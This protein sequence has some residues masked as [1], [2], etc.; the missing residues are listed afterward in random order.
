MTNPL[1][2]GDI[3]DMSTYPR[4]MEMM[5]KEKG[6][7]GVVFVSAHSAEGENEHIEKLIREAARMS[8]ALREACGALHGIEQGPVVLPEGSRRYPRFQRR[9][10]CAPRP[11]VV[12][13]PLQVPGEEGARRPLSGRARRRRATPGQR[14]VM[15]PGETFALLEPRP[16]RGAV[17]HGCFGRGGRSGGG[18]LG[19]PVA[20]KIASP[21]LLHK[22]EK[23]AV[24]LD[25]KDAEAVRQ[26]IG[27]MEGER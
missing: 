25:L 20:V 21:N 11:L 22:T 2:V 14:A 10:R 19:Y 4:I 5:L 24:A 8:P 1:D 12:A 7:D 18:R 15:D 27:R 3:Y 26:A 23:G 9:G 16:A 13:C 6:I 17:R